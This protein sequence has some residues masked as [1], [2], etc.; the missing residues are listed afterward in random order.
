MKKKIL[1]LL[2]LLTASHIVRAGSV[3]NPPSSVVG[4]KEHQPDTY[5]P[6]VQNYPSFMVDFL[7]MD[8]LYNLDSTKPIKFHSMKKVDWRGLLRGNVAVLYGI[9]INRS[10]FAFCPGIGWSTLHYAFT[11]KNK[12]D[13]AVYPTLKRDSEFRTEC[14]DMDNSPGKTVS[15][16]AFNI[17]FIDI[18]FRLRFNTVL[19]DPKVGFHAWLGVKLGLRYSASTTIDYKEYG[20]PASFIYNG[21]FNLSS[22][23]IGFQ[24]GVGYSR[25]GVTG[26]FHCTPLFKD[27][28]GPAHANL[29][30]S[31]SFGIYVDLV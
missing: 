14:E 15:H 26:G 2:L 24:T 6:L 25:F 17:N 1:L 7:R 8:Y 10:R 11:G 4:I 23:A 28:E 16:S 21:H 22:Y 5:L 3:D 30:R 29:L 9:R 13:Q 20:S 12:G 19:E 27:K 31:Y 18:L